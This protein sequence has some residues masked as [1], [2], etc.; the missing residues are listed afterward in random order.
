MSFVVLAQRNH[1]MDFA[2]IYAFAVAFGIM[3]IGKR[4]EGYFEANKYIDCQTLSFLIVMFAAYHLMTVNHVLFGRYY[5]DYSIFTAKAYAAKITESE[6]SIDDVIATPVTTPMLYNLNY[7]SDRSLVRF[8]E[9]TVESLMA[10]NKLV[11]AFQ[12]FGVTKILGFSAETSQKIIAATGAQLISDNSIKPE[13]PMTSK[14]KTLL[15]YLLR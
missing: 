8:D 4:L 9:G 5:D 2:F 1:V 12:E 13:I 15:M 11:Q 14:G 7:L 10:Q 6:T 3:V